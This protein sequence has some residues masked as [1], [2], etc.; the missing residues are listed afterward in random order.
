[1]GPGA[2][3]DKLCTIGKDG[4]SAKREWRPPLA[5]VANALTLFRI[6]SLPLIVVLVLRADN[7]TSL[8]ATVIFLLAALTDFLDGQ[9][10]RRAGAVTELGRVIDP[11][12]DRILISGTIIALAISGVLPV[13]GV[14]LVA[15]RDFFMIIGYKML[16]KKGVTLQVSFLGKAYTALFMAAI[17]IAMAGVEPGGVRLGWWLFWLGVAGS[18]LT[19]V[20]YTLKGIA[21][22]GRRDPVRQG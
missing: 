17:V 6:L 14:I 20:L 10:A 13:L 9:I 21:M 4:D 19:G 12:A 1:M 16:Q 7:G 3:C 22:A 11:L 15:T 2:F 5:V 8:A 18:L